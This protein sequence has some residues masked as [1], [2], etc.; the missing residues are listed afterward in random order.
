MLRCG[1]MPLTMEQSLLFR[2]N[3]DKEMGTGK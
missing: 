3:R 2:V 1:L